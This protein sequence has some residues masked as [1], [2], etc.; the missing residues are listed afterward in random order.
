MLAAKGRVKTEGGGSCQIGSSA[1][2]PPE[3][4]TSQILEGRTP[5]VKMCADGAGSS[6]GPRALPKAIM[7]R[8]FR[9]KRFRCE[10]PENRSQT[11]WVLCPSRQD[12]C[13]G[14][15]SLP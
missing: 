12:I 6:V 8:P 1:R 9:A 4:G 10:N 11:I 13:W 2:L 3:R 7:S 14:T 15:W 5:R